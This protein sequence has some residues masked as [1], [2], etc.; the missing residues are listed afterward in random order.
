MILRI[1]IHGSPQPAGDAGNAKRS[2][3]QPEGDPLS[4]L[5]HDGMHFARIEDLWLLKD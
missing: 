1:S 5:Q 3:G 4:L 2:A